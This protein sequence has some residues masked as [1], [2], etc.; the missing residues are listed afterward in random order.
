[1]EFRHI[2][3][4]MQRIVVEP[5]AWH[6]PTVADIIPNILKLSE[7]FSEQTLYAR[8]TVPPNVESATGCWRDFYERWP[9]ITRQE[10]DPHLLDLAPPL[11]K[12]AKADQVFDKPGFSIFSSPGLHDRLRKDGVGTLILSGTETDVCVYSSALGAVDL[13]YRVVLVEDAL[14]SPDADAHRTVLQL[15]APRLPQQIRVMS[16]AQLLAEFGEKFESKPRAM[17]EDTR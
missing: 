8:F 13:G 11:A 12:I 4:D 17:A 9:M 2:A 3:I 10:L 16:T 1:M 7:A 14:S 6:S 15:L 5:T